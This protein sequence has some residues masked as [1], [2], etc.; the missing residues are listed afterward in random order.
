MG[1]YLDWQS[2]AHL[3]L[4]GKNMATT[5]HLITADEL[6]AMPEDGRFHE[7]VRGEILVMTPAG[8]EHGWIVADLGATLRDFVRAN[9]LGIIVSGDAGFVLQRNP[10]TVRG[11]DIA[12]IRQVRIDKTGISPKYFEGPPD[13]AIEVVSPEDRYTE[14]DAKVQDYLAAGAQLVWV[15]N[16]RTRNVTAYGADRQIRVFTE[17]EE[18][19]ATELLPGFACRVADLFPK[20]PT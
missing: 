1:V 15:V 13:L 12:F 5:S 3:F 4:H 6:W 20:Q 14:V 8:L 7:L 18:L 16:P 9:S 10:D 11:P 2:Q 19:V 17:G